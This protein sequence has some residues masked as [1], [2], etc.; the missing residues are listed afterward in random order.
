METMSLWTKA[1]WAGLVVMILGAGWMGVVL[2]RAGVIR[3]LLFRLRVDHLRTYAILCENEGRAP[4]ALW[5]FGL[6]FVVFACGF[7][8][9]ILGWLE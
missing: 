6:G 9:P 2:R 8:G 4:L 7:L 5:L 1:A 3:G